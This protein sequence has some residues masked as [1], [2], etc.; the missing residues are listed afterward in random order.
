[1]KCFS[2]LGAFVYWMKLIMGLLSVLPAH[3]SA[4]LL[5]L[6]A[7]GQLDWGELFSLWPKDCSIL[8]SHSTNSLTA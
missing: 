2:C 4:V 8:Y 7:V 5:S 1:M 3:A 6:F